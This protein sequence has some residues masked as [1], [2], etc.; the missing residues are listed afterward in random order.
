MALSIIEV[1][2][3]AQ[4]KLEQQSPEL[5]EIGLSQLDH[6]IQLLDKGYGVETVLDEI[7]EHTNP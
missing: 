5:R 7:D 2:L 4:N 1:L 3:S 6:A